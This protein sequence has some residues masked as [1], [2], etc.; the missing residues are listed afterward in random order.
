MFDEF[1]KIKNNF[2]FSFVVREIQ[3]TL[4]VS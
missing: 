2:L 3:L 4:W 1:F